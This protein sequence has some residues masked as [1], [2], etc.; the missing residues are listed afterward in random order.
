MG[1]RLLLCD[2]DLS[3]TREPWRLHRG[4]SEALILE[5]E[6]DSLVSNLMRS[7]RSNRGNVRLHPFRIQL[8]RRQ[9]NVMSKLNIKTIRCIRKPD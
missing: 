7:L 9:E 5:G 3:K 4:K 1:R 8:L 2:E 6:T